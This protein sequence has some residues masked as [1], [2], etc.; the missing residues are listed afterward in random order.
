MTPQEQLDLLTRTVLNLC[1]LTDELHENL[2]DLKL[3]VLSKDE[4]FS[5]NLSRSL[6]RVRD[7]TQELNMLLAS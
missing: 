3:G 4:S 2:T 5:E 7:N 6:E 1:E